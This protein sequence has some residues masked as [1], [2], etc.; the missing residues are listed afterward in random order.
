MVSFLPVSLSEPCFAYLFP[1]T[2]ATFLTNLILLDFIT[3]IISGE[4]YKSLRYSLCSLLQYPHTASLL[5]PNT[6]LGNIS[7][8]AEYSEFCMNITAS[9][10][11]MSCRLAYPE[12]GIDRLPKTLVHFQQI[13]SHHIQAYGSLHSHCCEN[14][15]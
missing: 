8:T 3:L 11:M 4:E 10:D 12:N 1:T 15:T 2:C 5:G 7:L 9:L 14:L 13:T 6:F